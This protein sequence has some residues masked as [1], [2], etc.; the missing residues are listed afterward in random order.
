MADLSTALEDVAQRQT[1]L[2]VALD[3]P[4]FRGDYEF[5]LGPASVCG[6][7]LGLVDVEYGWP[8]RVDAERVDDVMALAPGYRRHPFIFHRDEL[9]AVG[10]Q[11]CEYED[12]KKRSG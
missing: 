6:S 8:T 11:M 12:I 4:T 5:V 10:I 7:V 2:I 3:T 9:V 1:V